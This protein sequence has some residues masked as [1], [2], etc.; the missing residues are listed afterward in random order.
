[1]KWQKSQKLS[2]KTV[3]QMEDRIFNRE[4]PASINDFIKDSKAE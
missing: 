3:V 4:D 2:M 1:M